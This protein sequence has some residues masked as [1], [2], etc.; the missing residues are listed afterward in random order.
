MNPYT[1][2]FV[3]YRDF[4]TVF[5]LSV[6]IVS[7]FAFRT[8]SPLKSRAE[9]LLHGAAKGLLLLNSLAFAVEIIGLLGFVLRMQSP[10]WSIFGLL[11]LITV[12]GVFQVFPIIGIGL[13][14]WWTI[15]R[16]RFFYT[17]RQV[18]MTIA[19]YGSLNLLCVGTY[20][21]VEKIMTT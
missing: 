16:H 2:P 11:F 1:K 12:I 14:A 4:V 10:L 13:F 6:L 19:K 3:D 9:T 15:G 7:C 20:F 5:L 8:H 17:N 21:F 18:S